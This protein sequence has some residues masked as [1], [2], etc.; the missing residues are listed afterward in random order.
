MR[1]WRISVGVAVIALYFQTAAIAQTTAPSRGSSS[2]IMQVGAAVSGVI[3]EILIRDGAQVGIG[4][5]L[6]RF[7]CRPL[8][9]EIKARLANLAAAQAAFE[10]THNGPRPDEV[11]IGEANVGVAQARAEEAQ[12]AFLRATALKEGV[13]TTRAQV[14]A[15]KRDARISAAQLEDSR[16]RLDLLHAGSREEDIAEAKARRDAASA[17]VDEANATLEQCTCAFP[18]GGNC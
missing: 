15:A 5:P 3:E 6:I 9:A 8:Q 10:R 7:D 16:K 18:W 13:S 11:A 2:S 1:E 17:L 12:D 14:L 4:Q